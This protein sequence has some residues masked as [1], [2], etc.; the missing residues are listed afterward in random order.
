M[1]YNT[2]GEIQVLNTA[3]KRHI[4]GFEENQFLSQ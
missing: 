4:L 3:D 2:V 1:S